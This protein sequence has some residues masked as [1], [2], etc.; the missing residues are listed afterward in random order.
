MRGSH[1][2]LVRHDGYYRKDEPYLDEI[3]Y[4]IIPDG[5]SRALALEQGT[6]Q[7][8]QWSDI[9]FFDVQRFK[10]QKNLEFTT[11]GYEYFAPHQW[12]EMNNRVAPMNDKRF[13][14]AIMH[15]IDREAMNKRIYFGNAKIATGPISS[16]TRFYDGKVKRYEF[17]VEKATKLLDEMGLK[18]GATASGSSSNI[19]CRPMARS[20]SAPANSSARVFP[21]PASISFWSA[22][23]WRAGPRRSATGTTR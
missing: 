13:R 23:T 16:K 12:L 1:V 17:S 5:A 4:V 20:I 22:P 6:V 2:H 19:W 21:R 11:K 7:L 18:P 9:E 15:L 3:I 10:S 8:V 14:Q